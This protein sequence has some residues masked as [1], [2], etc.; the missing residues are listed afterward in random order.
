MRDYRVAT[1]KYAPHGTTFDE[2]NKDSWRLLQAGSEATVLSSKNELVLIKPVTSDTPLDEIVRFLGESYDIILAEGF[3]RDE[4]P[5]IEVRRREV[6]SPSANIKGL[7]A[8]VTD[9][10]LPAGMKQFSLDDIKGLADFIE[11]EFIGPQGSHL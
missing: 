3:K 10:P 8:I 9:E 2:P 4:T 5:K 1:I 6:S 7:A 11:K